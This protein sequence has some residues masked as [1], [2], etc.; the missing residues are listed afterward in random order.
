MGAG[1]DWLRPRRQSEDGGECRLRSSASC[2]RAG[3]SCQRGGELERGRSECRRCGWPQPR[4]YAIMHLAIHDALN[5]I[6]RRYTPYL[7]EE[8]TSREASASAAVAA[9]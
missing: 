4:T 6:D 3:A 1:A 2:R 5:A 7:L 8:S 9:A